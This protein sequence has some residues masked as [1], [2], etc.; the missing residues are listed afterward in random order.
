MTKRFTVHSMLHDGELIESFDTLEEAM[1]FGSETAEMIIKVIVD[2]SRK[3]GQFPKSK[4]WAIIGIMD[5]GKPCKMCSAKWDFEEEI[6][7]IKK[8]E[9]EEQKN[10]AK[11]SH[12]KALRRTWRHAGRSETTGE[13][14]GQDESSN[15]EDT[16]PLA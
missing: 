9:E 3:I 4:E 11:R 1:Q 7:A 5:D 2:E 15:S 16:S 10:N 14:Q 8:K 6:E 13:K 12:N